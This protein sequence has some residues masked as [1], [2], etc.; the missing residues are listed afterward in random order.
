ML[1]IQ[2]IM[3]VQ[4]K[5]EKSNGTK[6][7]RNFLPAGEA[8]IRIKLDSVDTSPKKAKLQLQPIIRV[9]FG[10]FIL[11]PKKFVINLN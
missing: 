6:E 3:V 7:T 8:D 9:Y 2:I 1:V 11:L 10:N 4:K 5:R